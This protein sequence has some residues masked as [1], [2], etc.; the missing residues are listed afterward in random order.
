MLS[1]FVDF[2]PV[3]SGKMIVVS[4][5]FANALLFN[6]ILSIAVVLILEMITPI[7][8]SPFWPGLGET[9]DVYIVNDHFLML[10]ES[11]FFEN[12]VFQ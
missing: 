9:G 12:A 5:V 11:R 3:Q 1:S 2:E 4:P 10:S 7:G 6:N 8:S